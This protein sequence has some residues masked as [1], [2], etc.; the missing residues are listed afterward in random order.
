MRIFSDNR[1]LPQAAICVCM[2]C[3]VAGLYF[4]EQHGYAGNSLISWEYRFRDMV[5][6]TGRFT[7]P[8]RR[9]I[10][11]GIDSTSVSISDLDLKTLYADVDA[12]SVESRALH[13]IA[14]GWPWSRE[15]YSLLADRLLEAGARGVVFDLLLLK[16]A[17]GDEALQESI[18]RAGGR[19][20]VGAN[21]VEEVTGPGAS[22]WSINLPPRS[23]IADASPQHP[24][25]GYVNFWP[26]F[27]GIVRGAH[28]ATTLDQLQGGKGPENIGAET[29]LSLAA[30]AA[31]LLG[32]SLPPD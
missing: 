2:F 18:R 26:G 5:T 27:G 14:G 3:V 15:V 4:L 17:T 1:G 21:F 20:I 10:F 12:A 29:P 7:P 9:L 13:L 23:V 28:Y 25:I 8:D 19:I 16:S 32:A 22:A 11:V 31:A 30:R 24:S 6:A